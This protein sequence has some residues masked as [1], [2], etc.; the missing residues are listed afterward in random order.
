M[1]LS[2]Y[3][4]SDNIHSAP[5]YDES[6]FRKNHITIGMGRGNVNPD[7]TKS[8]NYFDIDDPKGITEEGSWEWKTG[9]KG[10][11]YNITLD[12]KTDTEY[13]MY[14]LSQKYQALKG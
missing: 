2:K 11:Y 6:F 3:C 1:F 14:L 12:E 4:Y 9:V 8:K 10:H 7:G 5:A 13:L